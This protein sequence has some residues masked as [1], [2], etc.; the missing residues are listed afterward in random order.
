[1]AKQF[2]GA[3][4]A[5]TGGTK[6]IPGSR[7][8][9]PVPPLKKEHREFYSA[10]FS[11]L[12]APIAGLN[13]FPRRKNSSN[14]SYSRPADCLRPDRAKARGNSCAVTT[15][16]VLSASQRRKSVFLLPISQP[17]SDFLG[18]K[19]TRKPRGGRGGSEAH[20]ARGLDSISSHGIFCT[21]GSPL[22]CSVKNAA[23]Q[24]PHGAD[25]CS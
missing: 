4:K 1:M 17:N 2:P 9:N 7:R 8:K 13:R 14:S 11:A 3:G 22:P 6:V 12:S 16:H 19:C 10:N 23:S 24:R 5:E 20:P 15:N 18:G 21:N 25:A